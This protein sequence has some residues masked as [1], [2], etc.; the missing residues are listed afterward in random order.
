MR[1]L[2]ANDQ[3]PPSPCD[4]SSSYKMINVY[5][6]IY[7]YIYT[8]TRML[9]PQAKLWL[10]IPSDMGRAISHHEFYWAPRFYPELAGTWNI[11]YPFP[12]TYSL[13]FRLLIYYI[14]FLSPL[15]YWHKCWDALLSLA[16]PPHSAKYNMS[17]V[18][19]P[20]RPSTG[21]KRRKETSQRSLFNVASSAI[22]EMHVKSCRT[23]YWMKSRNYPLPGAGLQPLFCLTCNLTLI[24]RLWKKLEYLIGP[25]RTRSVG[26][27]NKINSSQISTGDLYHPL[28]T[29]RCDLMANNNLEANGNDKETIAWQ[30]CHTFPDLLQKDAYSTQ[31][32]YL[33]TAHWSICSISHK[34]VSLSMF[35]SL[36]STI[37][38]PTSNL[39]KHHAIQTA[40]VPRV[41]PAGCLATNHHYPPGQL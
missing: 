39:Q 27:T 6:R 40:S 35:N 38:I 16:G 13:H 19:L 20:L 37:E 7:I 3:R 14:R 33:R 11:D 4:Y 25:R 23:D 1:R 32:V 28:P 24:V 10:A 5:I 36:F 9:Q 34:E 31:H 30:L 12:K 26:V 2:C 22:F 29:C 8:V 17:H 21:T 18:G 15:L 41:P